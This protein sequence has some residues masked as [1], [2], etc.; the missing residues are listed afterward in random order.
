MSNTVIISNQVQKIKTLFL[1]PCVVYKIGK[2]MPCRWLME[3]VHKPVPDILRSVVF[4][5]YASHFHVT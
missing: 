1:A 3:G 4:P 2:L 5:W